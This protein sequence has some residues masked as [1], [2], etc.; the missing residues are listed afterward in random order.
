MMSVTVLYTISFPLATTL[1]VQLL[2]F[3]NEPAAF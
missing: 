3:M 1:P 2:Y